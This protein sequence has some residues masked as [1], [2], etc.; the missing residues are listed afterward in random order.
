MPPPPKPKFDMEKNP[1]FFAVT[2][3]GPF[4]VERPSERS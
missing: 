4:S 3:K 2:F 1:F